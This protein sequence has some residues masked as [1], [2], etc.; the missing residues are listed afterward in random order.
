MSL[1]SGY[2]RVEYIQGT[3]TQ[4]I[5]TGFYPTNNT[6]I[7]VKAS[8]NSG[9]FYA[10]VMGSSRYGLYLV[11]SNSRIDM[12]FGSTGYKGS[13][14]TGLTFP[15]VV[16]M[17]NGKITANDSVYTFTTQ[18]AFTTAYTLP[19]FGQN[20][21]AVAA[22]YGEVYYCK[23]YE[24]GVL[25]RDFIPCVNPSGVAGLYDQ[26][27]SKFYGNAGS[28]SFVTGPVIITDP[29]ASPSVFEQVKAVYL[30]WS[31]VECDGYKIYR[32]GSLLGATIN[33]YFID[34]TA[35]DNE[36]YVYTLTAYNDA[37]ESDPA[38]L[39]VYTRSG[40]FVIKPLI[41]SAFFR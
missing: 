36:T 28:G 26:V 37:G 20:N 24:G 1:P 35:D 5:D 9:N 21:G 29:P 7:E 16:T 30:K 4:Y 27:N 15:A 38:E 32:N 12:A 6:K 39:T 41:Q 22:V 14:I 34:L 25:V 31:A 2:R 33:T 10:A 19:L 23:I 8:V 17:E 13:V 18:S 11:T 40:Y 3:G